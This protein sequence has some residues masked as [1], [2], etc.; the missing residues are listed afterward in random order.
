MAASGTT[1]QGHQDTP[2]YLF[3]SSVDDEVSKVRQVWLDLGVRSP[4]KV[5]K[6]IICLPLLNSEELHCRLQS[7]KNLLQLENADLRALAKDEDPLLFKN[8]LCEVAE[9]IVS[10][11]RA[12]PAD[13]DIFE[14]V[15]SEPSLLVEYDIGL[16]VAACF[17]ILKA[18][19]PDADID[20]LTV[21]N[22]TTMALVLRDCID[23][24]GDPG[25]V[26]PFLAGWL[27]GESSHATR[28]LTCF[29][30]STKRRLSALGNSWYKWPNLICRSMEPRR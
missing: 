30:Q 17:T 27:I 6:L 10:L 15:Q 1:C 19:I 16:K 23:G 29:S 4:A 2:I 9:S 5:S 14:L 20:E 12:L 7:L 28:R 13:C 3:P 25:E 24:M 8:S 22:P 21:E 26:H 11:R 18:A